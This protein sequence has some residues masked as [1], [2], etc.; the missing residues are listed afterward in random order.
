VTTG[1]NKRTTYP[2]NK[3]LMAVYV[4][5]QFEQTRDV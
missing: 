2:I 4:E 1:D 3:D 5:E